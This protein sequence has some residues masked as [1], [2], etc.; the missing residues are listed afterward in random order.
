M[1]VAIIPARGGSKRIPNKNIKDFCGKPM[2]AHAIDTAQR[3]G[4]FE[5]VI[6]STDCPEIAAIATHY[7]ADVP[8]MRPASLA[9]D[10]TG[11]TAVVCHALSFLEAQNVTVD[12]CCCLY[13]TTPLL[14]AVTLQQGLA[15]LAADASIDFVFSACH[16]SFPIQRALIQTDCGGV[17][18][19][20]SASIGKR[21]QDLTPTYHDAGQFYW[22]RPAAF[23]DPAR[24]VFGA[25]GRMLV[26]PAHRV[27]DIDTLEDWC[28]A[29]LLYQLLQQD[30][31]QGDV[32]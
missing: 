21:S 19:F 2:L 31:P 4:C 24:S 17:A 23:L 9:D 15:Q 1:R 12:L 16:F 14:Q 8:F 3:S 26:L 10:Y 5:R 28:R 30:E 32:E 6:V 29:E 25:S 11:T 22:G 27:Q 13:A 18:P 7:G 20:D